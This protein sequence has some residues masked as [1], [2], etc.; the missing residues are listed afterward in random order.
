MKK[1]LLPREEYPKW[2][3]Q[4]KYFNGID[5]LVMIMIILLYHL[6]LVGMQWDYLYYYYY[7]VIYCGGHLLQWLSTAIAIY[8]GGHPLQQL[9]ITTIIYCNGQVTYYNSYLL[10]RSSIT[11]VIYYNGWWS[12]MAAIHCNSHLLQWTFTT[13]VR[14]SIATIRSYTAMV[15]HYK[16]RIIY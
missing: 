15:I 7:Q 5:N 16:S 10:Q 12:T 14:S 2:R 4:N 1:N 9:S 3:E 11:T 6:P 13:T 8:Y